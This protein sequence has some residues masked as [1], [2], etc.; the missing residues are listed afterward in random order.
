MK[1]KTPYQKIKEFEKL[2]ERKRKRL[3]ERLDDINTQI[4]KLSK[5]AKAIEENIYHL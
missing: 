2:K 5:K 1:E 4:D 3:M